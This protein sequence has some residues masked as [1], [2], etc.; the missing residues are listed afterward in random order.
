M[1]APHTN[2]LTINFVPCDIPPANGYRV[3]YWPVDHPNDIRVYPV[4]FFMSP[5]VINDTHD[6]LGTSYAGTI[7]G[8]CGEDKFGVHVPFAA[9][10]VTES[11]S[12]SIG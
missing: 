7:Q 5:I 3:T 11:I 12:G 4:N 8:D 10:H 1:A 6:P 2:T 9:P